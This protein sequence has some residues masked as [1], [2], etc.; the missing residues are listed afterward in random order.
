MPDPARTD[1]PPPAAT[2]T[3]RE[4]AAH[5]GIKPETLY[6][7][8]ARGWVRAV[9]QSGTRAKRYLREDVERLKIRSQA[10]GGKGAAAASALHWGVPVITTGITEIAADGPHYRGLPARQLAERR[11]PFENTAEFLW[12]GV[13]HDQALRWPGSR[14]PAPFWR[15]C[16]S[17][18]PGIVA[19]Y[20]DRLATLFHLLGEAQGN[21]AAN[22][23]DALLPLARQALLMATGAL[24]YLRPNGTLLAPR[25]RQR[26]AALAAQAL[27]RPSDAA[28]I[29]HLDLALTLG[30]DHELPPSTF[31][32]RVVA[33]TGGGLHSCLAGAASAFHGVLSGTDPNGLEGWINAGRPTRAVLRAL[34]TRHQQG[35]AVSGFNHPLYPQGDPRAVRLLA[36]VAART[37][38]DRRLTQLRE[39]MQACTA[40]LGWTP[41]FHS[42]LLAL[43]FGHGLPD[44]TAAALNLLGR[45]A[46]ITAH[47]QEQRLSRVL[48]RPRAQYLAG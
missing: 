16:E 6:A 1:S 11:L 38:E 9:A 18:P 40:K 48:I 44:G 34:Q 25:P 47:V 30:A 5:L 20:A 26:V 13:W 21:L 28:L 45:L 42:G 19:N 32:A 15:S 33:S 37:G 29:D 39:V 7:Y 31:V 27:G 46:G 23:T 4:V 41:A 43:Q 24:G 36:E 12:T 10:H 3:S 8:V 17:L 35:R 2:M 22:R 14:L